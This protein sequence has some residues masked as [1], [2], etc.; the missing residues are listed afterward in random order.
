MSQIF[1]F[2]KELKQNNSREWFSEHKDFYE[3]AKY[4]AEIIMENVYHELEKLEELESLKKFRI[5]RDVRFS[6]DKTPYK[7]HFSGH[8]GRK[9]PYKR[10]GFYIHLED[11][12]S[13][14]GAGFWGPEK[15][16]L[17]RI[18]KS[19][20]ASDDLEQVLNDKMLLNNFGEIDGDEL[21]TA[22]KGF[23]KNHPRI[24]L[25]KKK[26]FILVKHFKD[27]EVLASDFPEKVAH[28]YHILM[29]FFHYMTEVLTTNEN[30][31]LIV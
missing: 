21:K 1:K 13:F 30:G 4:E 7:T 23:D 29:P 6:H 8:T 19:I 10:G 18:R 22:P 12:N 15:E 3:R 27:Q 25:L 2:L 31:E 20:E 17:F 26:Q 28:A 5:Y 16:D 11:G 9:K 24:N 14:I